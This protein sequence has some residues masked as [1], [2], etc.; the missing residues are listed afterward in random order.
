[1]EE[2]RARAAE[3]GETFRQVLEKT[4]RLGLGAGR[5][6]PRREPFRVR[7]HPL[8]LKPGFHGVS[9]NQLYDQLEAEEGRYRA[10]RPGNQASQRVAEGPM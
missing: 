4:L 8:G 10:A 5:A 1:M 3:T 2:L 6:S 9:L 7:P